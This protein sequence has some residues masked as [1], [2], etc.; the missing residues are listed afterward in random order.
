MKIQPALVIALIALFFSLAGT[1]WAVTQLP[2]NS[3]GP[4]QIRTNAVTAQK[5]ARNAVTTAKIRDGA[6]TAAKLAPGVQTQGP[7]GPAG[8]KGDPGATGPAGDPGPK[9]DPGATGPAGSKG[10]PGAPGPKGDPGATGPAAAFQEIRN[11]ATFPGPGS[12]WGASAECPDGT[13]VVAGGWRFISGAATATV[14]GSYPN[15]RPSLARDA[16]SVDYTSTAG[17][18]IE[19]IAI[20]TN[21]TVTPSPSP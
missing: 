4:Q 8:P 14:T 6:V 3:V 15:E 17:G 7:Q 13:A 2:R 19:V 10:D 12:A 5:V 20:C 18:E 21:G 9:G 1:S 11:R 16:W